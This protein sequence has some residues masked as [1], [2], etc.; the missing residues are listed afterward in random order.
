MAQIGLVLTAVAFAVLGGLLVHRRRA[1]RARRRRPVVAGRPLVFVSYA[2]E[3]RALVDAVEVELE[4]AGYAVW[5]DVESIRAGE[6]WRAAIV[7]G[8]RRS[9]AVLV[10]VSRWSSTSREVARELA[11]ADEEDRP[12]VPLVV[13]GVEHV[14]DSLRYVLAGAQSIDLGRLPRREAM[15]RVRAA[16]GAA[17]ATSRRRHRGAGAG[18]H[19]RIRRT[20][21]RRDR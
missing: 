8:V 6:A 18:R 15:V 20:G 4:A 10:V 11:L 2:A 9:A 3:D 7:A 19:G 12:I 1:A 16:V 13:P 14:D 21:R 5:R 17:V